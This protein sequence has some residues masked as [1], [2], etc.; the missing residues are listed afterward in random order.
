[1]EVLGLR[2]NIYPTYSFTVTSTGTL[3]ITNSSNTALYSY[4]STV[5]NGTTWNITRVGNTVT[6]YIGGT[7]R[8]TTTDSSY[9]FC[10]YANFND[11]GTYN[12][13]STIKPVTI[14]SS[15][16]GYYVGLGNST[17]GNGIYSQYMSSTVIP[18]TSDI[19]INGT[20]LTVLNIGNT[21]VPATG[22]MNL[23]S[24]EGMLFCNAADVGKTVT[25]NYNILYQ[26]TTPC[27][28]VPV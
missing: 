11:A 9:S 4:P 1:M 2:Q 10:V 20:P 19:S 6:F 26:T 28:I 12:A 8:Y 21:N 14:N 23:A 24:E 5:T 16:T 18:N 17:T 3:S 15:G 13:Y 7:L 22:G 27:N 25:G